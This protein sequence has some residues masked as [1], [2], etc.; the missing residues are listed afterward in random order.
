MRKLVSMHFHFNSA[1]IYISA[2][3]HPHLNWECRVLFIF[4]LFYGKHS[5]QG[6]VHKKVTLVEKGCLLLVF[7]VYY[8]FRKYA[9]WYWVC[10]KKLCLCMFFSTECQ[11][12][13]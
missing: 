7:R 4:R 13:V 5:F 12:R 6:C 10:F 3:T 2:T 11:Y 9:C 1:F 8:T